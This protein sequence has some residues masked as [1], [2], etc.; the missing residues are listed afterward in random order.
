VNQAD[1]HNVRAIRVNVTAVGDG[2]NRFGV[3]RTL[4]FDIPFRN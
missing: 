1:F 3:Q 2:A 4:Q